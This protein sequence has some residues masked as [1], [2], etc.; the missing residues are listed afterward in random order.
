MRCKSPECSGDRVKR[1]RFCEF[2]GDLFA[3]V[4]AEIEQEGK[5]RRNGAISRKTAPV[6][7]S[8]VEPSKPSPGRVV[9]GYKDSILAALEDGERTGREL[10]ERCGTKGT[11]RSFARARLALLEAGEITQ[12]PGTSKAAKRYALAES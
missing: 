11:D 6:T 9:E 12:S 2:H 8:H 1:S 10:S 4:R 5:T 7:V 3:R